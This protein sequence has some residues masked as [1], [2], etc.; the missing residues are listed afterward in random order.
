MYIHELKSPPGSRKRR[1]IVGRGAGSGHGRTSGRGQKGQGSRSKGR[2][3]V[4]TLEGGQMPLAKRLPKVG[5]H[6]KRPILNQVLDVEQLNQLAK[7][8]VVNA[9]FLKSQGFIE[10]AR[11]PFKILGDGELSVPVVIE[12]GSVSET[13][14]E[15]ILKAGGKIAQAGE[16][17]APE[18]TVKTVKGASES[19]GKK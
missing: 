12:G 5:F 16:A 2:M 13:A 7:G 3:L 1:K 14:R 4:G 9:A 8:T 6:S 15:K 11:R 18:E 19:K 10:S 17:A